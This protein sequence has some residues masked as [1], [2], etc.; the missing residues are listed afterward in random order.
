METRRK[1]NVPQMVPSEEAPH[2]NPSQRFLDSYLADTGAGAGFYASNWTRPATV[3]S[4][5]VQEDGTFENR[6]VF[7]FADA[8]LPDGVHVDTAGNG[9]SFQHPILSISRLGPC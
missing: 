2:T 3:Y 8:G 9:P 4:F 6:K 5:D 1:S 7:A